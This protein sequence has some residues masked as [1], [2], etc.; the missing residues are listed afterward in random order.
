MKSWASQQAA[1]RGHCEMMLEM[2]RADVRAME[3]KL[4]DSDES[5]PVA[6]TA[7]EIVDLDLI[8]KEAIVD[9]K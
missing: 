1:S 9:R 4:Q 6:F 3:A 2:R 8:S 5:V 7:H